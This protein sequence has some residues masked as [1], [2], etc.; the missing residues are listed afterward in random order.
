VSVAI[1]GTHDT[2][3]MAEWW[4]QTDAD[5]RIA[6]VALP[7]VRDSGIRADEPFSERV[8]DS[9][10]GTLFSARSDLLLIAIQD[11]FGWSDRINVPAVVSDQNWSWRMPWPVDRMGTEP[12]VTRRSSVIRRLAF[13][14][15]RSSR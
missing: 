8:L 1:S 11:A 7:Q 5:D 12:E 15:G 3:T 4:A 14:S 13:E 2:E 9:L 6:A 10:L